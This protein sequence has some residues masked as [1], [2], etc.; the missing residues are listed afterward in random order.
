[1]RDN[2]WLN[3]RLDNIWNLLFHD[4]ERANKVSAKFK[5]RWKNKFGHIRMQKDKSSEIVVNSLFRYDV[6]PEYIIDVTIA[7]ELVHYSHGFNSPLEKK[8]KHP[9]KGGIVKKELINRG[10]GSMI[11]VEKNFVK[12]KWFKLYR[13]LTL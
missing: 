13:M 11:R 9:H 3:Q 6:I 10:F 4:I 1:M 2:E 12:N 8:Y 5:G 7:H